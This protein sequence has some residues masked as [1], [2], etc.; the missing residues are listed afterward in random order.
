MTDDA[1]GRNG[2][3][4]H[5][6]ITP[7]SLTEVGAGGTGAEQAP[8]PPSAQP[9]VKDMVA[10]IIAERGPFKSLREADLQRSVDQGN[11]FPAGSKSDAQQADGLGMAA[12]KQT[13]VDCLM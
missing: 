13:I 4:L 3:S 7:H 11:E 2:A 1:V 6:S 5:L 8:V 12:V 9:S 10:R